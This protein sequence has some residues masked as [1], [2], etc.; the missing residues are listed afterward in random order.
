[1]CLVSACE[2]DLA[3][4]RVTIMGHMF[5]QSCVYSYGGGE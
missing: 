3:V 1:M 5:V 2:P 4:N